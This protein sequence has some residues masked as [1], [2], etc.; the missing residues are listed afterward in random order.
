MFEERVT[1]LCGGLDA[2]GV[3]E[4]A[5]VA[6]AYAESWG[7]RVYLQHKER[8]VHRIQ[9]Y[10]LTSKHIFASSKRPHLR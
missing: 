5:I 3:Y 2:V 1:H 6:N 10:H 9:N 7:R 8:L 4:A